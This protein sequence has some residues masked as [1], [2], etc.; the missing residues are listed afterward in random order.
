MTEGTPIVQLKNLQYAIED[1][2]ILD[3]ITLDIRAREIFAVMGLSGTGKTTLLRLIS[4][5]IRP[6]GGQIIVSGTDITALDEHDLI[7]VRRQMGFVFQYGAL[8]DS[9]NVRQNVGFWLD[10]H[11]NLPESAIA[12]VVA[13]QLRLVGLPGTEHLFP[14][15]L[16]G[17]MQKRVG[18]ARALVAEPRMLLYDEPTSGLDPVI[19]ANIDDLI[20]QL[21]DAIGVTSIVVSH[22]VVSVQRM[23]DRMTLLYEGKMRL[24]GTTGD[25][26]TSTDPVVRQFMEGTTN[27]PI[28]IV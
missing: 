20:V 14:A 16:S 7:E 15:E 19:A 5:L 23:A 1:H 22:D 21:R 18:I 27:G 24:I 28:Q 12:P 2:V 26:A 10:E 25:F 11:T 3:G 6:T 17:G 9:L 13:A 4:G 8:F